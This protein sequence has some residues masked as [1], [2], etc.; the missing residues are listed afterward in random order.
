MS[1]LFYTNPLLQ[2]KLNDVR[3]YCQMAKNHCE[4]GLVIQTEEDAKRIKGS[5]E[6]NFARLLI[7]RNPHLI[8]A[9]EPELFSLTTEEGKQQGTTPDF[10]IYNPNTDRITFV[11]LTRAEKNGTDPKEKQKRIMETA[12]PTIKYVVLYRRELAKIQKKHRV[13]F[14]KKPDLS[15]DYS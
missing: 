11:E 13:K 7:K 12:A 14:L 1:I 9:Y 4:R 3:Y 5:V 2:K 10:R 6:K 8:V 15:N